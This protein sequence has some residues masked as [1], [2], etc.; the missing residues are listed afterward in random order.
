[1]GTPGALAQVVRQGRRRAVVGFSLAG[2][3]VARQAQAA[4]DP[5]ASTARPTSARWTRSSRFMPTTRRRSR[6]AASSSGRARRRASSC[7][8][9]RSSTWTS[10]SSCSVRHDTNVTPNTGGTFG[11]SSIAIAGPRLRSAAATARQALLGLA[12]A[13]LGVPVAGLTVSRRRRLGRRQVGHLR[14]ARRRPAAS[15]S[16]WP[17]R[18]LNPGV[19]PSK[20]IASYR[21]VGIARVP[22]VDI[23]AKV[24]GTYTYL[25]SDPRAR[26]AAR[27]DRPAPRPGGLRRRHGDRGRLGRRALDPRASATRASFVAATS[28]ASSPRTSTTRSRRP[29]G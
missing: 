11:S 17:R 7:S 10:A 6:P 24:A 27:P 21:L 9:P 28:S 14:R 26:D 15:T 16:R 12:S 25:Q 2:A 18:R 29:R 22:R 3:A 5:F 8:W 1:M 20:P 19:A 4:V 23:P 13:Q